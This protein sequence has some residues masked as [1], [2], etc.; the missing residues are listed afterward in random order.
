MPTPSVI[1]LDL[2]WRIYNNYNLSKKKNHGCLVYNINITVVSL[3]FHYYMGCLSITGSASVPLSKL[4]PAMTLGPNAPL[5]NKMY[6][7]V[8]YM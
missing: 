2:K 3:W 7:L 6:T 4:K 5:E 1:Y 8:I